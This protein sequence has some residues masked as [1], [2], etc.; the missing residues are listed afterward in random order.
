MSKFLYGGFVSYRHG[1]PEQEDDDLTSFANQ[2]KDA[3]VS[4]LRTQGLEV[5][6]DIERMKGGYILNP[7]LGAS[8][9][10]SVCMIVI[11]VRDYMSLTKP[12]CAAELWTMLQ[13]EQERFQKLGIDPTKA[14]KGHI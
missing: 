2:V 4:E 5:F 10:K 12:Y 11:F 8:L 13:C 6:F 14:Q 1:D 3:F 7:V 9:C